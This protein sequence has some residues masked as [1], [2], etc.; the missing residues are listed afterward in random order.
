MCVFICLI[1]L[2]VRAELKDVLPG[3]FYDVIHDG[4]YRRTWDE[5]VIE[6][7]DICALDD[8]NDIGYYSSEFVSSNTMG[9]VREEHDRVGVAVTPSQ[10]F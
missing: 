4:K 2:K 6:D 9:R 7:V 10:T 5:N 1:F 8:N 3:T